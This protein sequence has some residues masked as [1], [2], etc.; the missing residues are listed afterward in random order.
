MGKF[1]WSLLRTCITSATMNSL[2]HLFTLAALLA[3]VR[4]DFAA[5]L[6][7]FVNETPTGYTVTEMGRG[8]QNCHC[9]VAASSSSSASSSVF[10]TTTGAAS[11]VAVTTAA[12]TTTTNPGTTAADSSA[13]ADYATSSLLTAGR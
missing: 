5:Q 13:F 12:D 4:T 6:A 1:V 3:T 10:T 2:L 9:R 11:S 7:A 8:G